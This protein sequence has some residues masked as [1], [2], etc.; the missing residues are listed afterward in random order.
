MI[1]ESQIDREC[2]A[3]PG[4]GRLQAYYRLSGLARLQRSGE[5]RKQGYRHMLK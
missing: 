2:A 4:L 1:S 3:C 5:L